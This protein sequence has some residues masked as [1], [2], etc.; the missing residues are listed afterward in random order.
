MAA[1]K[2][3]DW[4]KSRSTDQPGTVRKATGIVSEELNRL[5][6]MRGPSS[7][8]QDKNPAWMPQV[9]GHGC[10]RFPKAKEHSRCRQL[11]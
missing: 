9:N 11:R 1:G 6:N 5:E 4:R 2:E 7:H 3:R 8:K 10:I